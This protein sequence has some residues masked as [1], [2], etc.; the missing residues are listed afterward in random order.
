MFQGAT[1]FNQYVGDWDVSGVGNMLNMFYEATIFNQDLS[2]WCVPNL[3]V[4]PF[5]FSKYSSLA[6]SN[7]PDW[8]NCP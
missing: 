1:A 5:G 7:H 3:F 8:G 4:A 6:L 2:G